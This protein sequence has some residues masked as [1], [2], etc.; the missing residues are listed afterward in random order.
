MRAVALCVAALAVSAA[1]LV[2]DDH[3]VLF[4]EDVDFS[5][6]KTFAMRE[7]RITSERPELRFP[8]VMTA[9]DEAIRAGLTAR[10][11][12][13]TPDRADLVVEYRATGVDWAIGP[14]GRPSVVQPGNRGRGGRAGGATVN[15]TE[16]T[17]VIDLSHGDPALLVWRGV[18]HDTEENAGTL[19]Q[20]LPRD[21]AI[22]LAKYPVRK[23]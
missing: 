22:L 17:L 7:R 5:T 11:L 9:I 12:K 8:A 10:G 13:E 16:V 18:Y 23:K 3:S 1:V 14:F 15:F 2:A 20:A 21:A 6:F 19:A 4:D